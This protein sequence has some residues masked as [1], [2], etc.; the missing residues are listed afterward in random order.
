MNE[1]M[2]RQN[3][4]DTIARLEKERKEREEAQGGQNTAT[5]D[6]TRRVGEL[7]KSERDKEDELNKKRKEEQATVPNLCTTSR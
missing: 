7:E 2:F 6:L 5:A 1:I 3:E 4:D